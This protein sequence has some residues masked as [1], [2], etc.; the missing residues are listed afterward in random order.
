[1]FIVIVC[2]SRRQSSAVVV[3]TEVQLSSQLLIPQNILRSNKYS[4]P[5][6][7][8]FILCLRLWSPITVF[9][10]GLRLRSPVF[11]FRL[12]SPSSSS[13]SSSFFVFGYQLQIGLE[14]QILILERGLR[15]NGCAT[16]T[17]P[18]D[19][20]TPNVSNRGA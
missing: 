8:G 6:R 9:V 11:V 1:M 16:I 10:S 17:R 20:V 18:P 5:V 14:F 12:P 7:L 2:G 15:F 3:V 4:I 13:S 19:P